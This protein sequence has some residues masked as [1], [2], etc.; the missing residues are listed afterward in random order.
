MN[1]N[2]IFFSVIVP[3]YNVEKYIEKCI[4]S[5]FNNQINDVEIIIVNDGSTDNSRNIINKYA[6]R[7]NIVIIDQ[8]N[9]GLSAARNSGLKIAKGEYILFL[10][11]DDYLEPEALDILY[12]VVCES[13]A[14]LY[15]FARKEV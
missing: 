13:R 10:D 7:D 5:I 2:N 6:E 12:K 8:E 11:S 4:E 15:V 3:V 14:D 1:E 9:A